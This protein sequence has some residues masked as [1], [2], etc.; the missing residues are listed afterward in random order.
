MFGI[1]HFSA[2]I[3][4]PQSCILAVGKTEKQVIFSE[5]DPQNPYKV[6]SKMTVTLSCDHRVVDGAV[7]AQWL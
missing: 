3:N 7:G 6:V 5:S 1:D 2:V 4:P